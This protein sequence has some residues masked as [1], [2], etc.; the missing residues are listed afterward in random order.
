MLYS[1]I[2]V[3]AYG[4]GTEEMAELLNVF[5]KDAKTESGGQIAFSLMF[6]E[7]HLL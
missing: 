2:Q 3:L 5:N 6:T 4:Q 1:D 7:T